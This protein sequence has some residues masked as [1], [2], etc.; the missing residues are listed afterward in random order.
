MSLKL[1]IIEDREVNPYI[2]INDRDVKIVMPMRAGIEPMI[3]Y[4]ETVNRDALIELLSEHNN[5]KLGL[6]N[7]ELINKKQ[8]IE[9]NNKN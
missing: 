1:L 7:I 9:Q 5:D 8:N 4:L 3:E 2:I 6:L